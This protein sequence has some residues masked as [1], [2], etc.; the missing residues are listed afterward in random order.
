MIEEAILT[1]LKQ[2]MQNGDAT[3]VSVLRLLR[4]EIHNA[5]IAA[6]ADL[7]EAEQL[8]IVRKELKKRTEAA[9]LYRT[10][11]RPQ[12]AEAEEAEAAV[13][14]RYLPAAA[15]PAAVEAFGRQVLAELPDRTPRQKGVLIQRIRAQFGEQVDGGEVARLADQLL[16]E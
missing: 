3:A 16:S 5:R 14:Q 1:D 6:G 7:D 10:A 12:Q 9:A 2:A 8:K 11:D 4:S 13:L 15:D